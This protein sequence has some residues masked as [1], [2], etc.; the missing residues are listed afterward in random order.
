MSTL[1]KAAG[2]PQNDLKFIHIAGTNGKGSVAAF[3]ASIFEKAGYRTGLYTSPHLVDICERIRVNG[4]KIDRK[5]FT[6]WTAKL[7][8]IIHK[9]NCTFFEALTAI[10]LLHFRSAKAD[11]VM[12]EVGLGGRLDA[13]NI[14]RPELCIITNIDWDHQKYLGDS[15]QDIAYEKAGI[16]KDGVPC[17]T[18]EINPEAEKTIVQV[19][20]ERNSRFLRAT[21]ICRASKIETGIDGTSFRL[22]VSHLTAELPVKIPLAGLHQVKN[23]CLA[24][25]A[26][27][28]LRPGWK[29]IRSTHIRQG[30]ERIDWPARFQVVNKIP[31]I[32]LDAAHNAG[33]FRQ[34]VETLMAVKADRRVFFVIGLARD[35]AYSE[36]ISTVK[37]VA[38]KIF[39]VKA[40]TH[41]ALS[42]DVLGR[43]LERQGCRY[44]VFTSTQAGT[45]QALEESGKN[46]LI[47]ITGS[48]FV[49][50]EAINAIKHLTN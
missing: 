31:L 29:K 20:R 5:S 45:R 32:V 49:V 26:A 10:A 36:I 43:E 15:L 22:N 6:L 4:E 23:A 17:L 37:P 14:V 27:A 18:G 11:I 2:D 12:W 30:L 24:A 41:R 39:A 47:C 1:L 28:V 34:L 38:E 8:G 40:R 3:L 21:D 35:K 7:E 16:I 46:T 13:T 9:Y 19:C 44:A 42:V 33:A 50:G 48:H 25:G